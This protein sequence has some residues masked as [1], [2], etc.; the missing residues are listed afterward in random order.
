MSLSVDYKIN[1]QNL[2]TALA[3]AGGLIAWGMRIESRI[4]VVEV[5]QRTQKEVDRRQDVERDTL[6]TDLHD[7]GNKLDAKLDKLVE[8]H[9]HRP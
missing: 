5:E 2:L 9:L 3:M 4:S 8:M 1:V 6:R 7:L